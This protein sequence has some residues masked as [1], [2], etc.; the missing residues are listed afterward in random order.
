MRSGTKYLIDAA[1]ALE[2]LRA[3]ARRGKSSVGGI[4]GEAE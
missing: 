4:D 3:E 2:V 1:G